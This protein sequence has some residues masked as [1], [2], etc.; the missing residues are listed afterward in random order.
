MIAARMSLANRI[1]ALITM[2]LLPI[3]VIDL[4]EGRQ[5]PVR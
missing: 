3:T 2:I 4:V 5:R 1:L